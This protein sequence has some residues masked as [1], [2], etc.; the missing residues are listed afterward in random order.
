MRVRLIKRKSVEDFVV[1]HAGSRS[2]FRIWLMLIKLADWKDAADIKRTF[3][4]ADLLGNGSERVVF[5]I[6]GNNYRMICKYHVGET[7]FHLY[8]K[9]IGTHAAY[10]SLCRKNEQYTVNMY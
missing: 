7:T 2:S 8:I 3:G 9:W 4:S 1:E 10:T 5:N 6:A